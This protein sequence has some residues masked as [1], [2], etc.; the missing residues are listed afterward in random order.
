MMESLE[1]HTEC[2]WASSIGY[3]GR[4]RNTKPPTK[5]SFIVQPIVNDVSEVING[6]PNST[7][8]KEKDKAAK[9]VVKTI[10]IALYSLS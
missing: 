8:K 4:T 7:E 10:E 6:S 9:K 5:L 2:W 1:T 3:T